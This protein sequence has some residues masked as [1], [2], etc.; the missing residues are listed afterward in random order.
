[1][2]GFSRVL[3]LLMP[4]LLP[5]TVPYPSLSSSSSVLRGFDHLVLMEIEACAILST[6]FYI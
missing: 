5:Q 6:E 2:A 3:R 4:V 1:M